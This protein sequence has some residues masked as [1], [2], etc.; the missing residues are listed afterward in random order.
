MVY[1]DLVEPLQLVSDEVAGQIFKAALQYS[2]T[3][4]QTDFERIEAQMLWKMISANIDRD[5]AAY[6]KRCDDGAYA[7]YVSA[8]N[9]AGKDVLPRE[10]WERRRK[11]VEDF[12]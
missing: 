10:E 4:E 3:G 8:R 5:S 6:K 12:E 2:A 11:G 9:H 7:G 1:H